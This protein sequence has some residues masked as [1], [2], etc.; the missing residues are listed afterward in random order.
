MSEASGTASS[1]VIAGAGITGIFTGNLMTFFRMVNTLALLVLLNYANITTTSLLR[2]FLGGLL[3]D[4]A[5]PNLYA[6]YFN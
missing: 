6:D 1:S 2:G 5:V 3:D 4:S